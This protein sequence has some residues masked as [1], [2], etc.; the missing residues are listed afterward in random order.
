MIRILLMLIGILSL[1]A[2]TSRVIQCGG[3][4][5][6]D[7]RTLVS[8]AHNVF[9]GKILNKVGAVSFDDHPLTHTRFRVRVISNIKG[10]LDG[11]VFVDLAGGTR[12]LN[13]TVIANHEGLEKLKKGYTYIFATRNHSENPEQTHLLFHHPRQKDLITN[14][15]TFD[16]DELAQLAD[17]SSRV[18]ELRLSF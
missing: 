11:E 4:D 3:P 8:T 10:N 9:V 17:A 14:D 18:Q 6:S 2:C 13:R 1:P 16:S 7:D 12:G 5:T 15:L